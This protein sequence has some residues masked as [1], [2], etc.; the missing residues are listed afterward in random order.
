MGYTGT[1]TSIR[2]RMSV[3]V[4]LRARRKYICT[5]LKPYES[6]VLIGEPHAIVR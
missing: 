2:A 6:C 5:G 1:H 4:R 3:R